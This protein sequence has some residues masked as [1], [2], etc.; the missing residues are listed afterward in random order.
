LKVEPNGEVV[1]TSPPRV[2]VSKIEA[3]I[4]AHLGWI[5]QIQEMLSQR[6]NLVKDQATVSLFGK[7]YTK[8]VTYDQTKRIGVTVVQ[9]QIVI[10][11]IPHPTKSQVSGS[12]VETMIERFIKN[13]AEKYLIPRTHQLAETMGIEFKRITLKQQKSRWG[14]CSSQGNL[15]FNW[16]LVHYPTPVIDYVIIHELAHRQEMNHSSAFWSIVKRYDPAFAQHRGW[17]KRNGLP[18]D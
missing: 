10:N 7:K 16:R 4:Q 15:N 18:V 5:A 8:N 12:V 1:V 3:F 6:Q 14:S 11:C 13:T 9:D 2:P 17:L